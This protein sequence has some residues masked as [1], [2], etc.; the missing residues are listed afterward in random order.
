MREPVN[1]LQQLVLRRL[2]EL[3]DRTG[4]MSTRAAAERSGGLVSYETLRGIARG[5]HSGKITDRT[6]E[7]I[8]RALDVPLAQ[9]YLTARVPRPQSRWRWPERFDRLDAA[10]RRLVEDVAAAMLEAYE[11]GVRDAR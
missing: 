11:K 4:P 1:E 9:V 3:G 6:A 10:Q 2:D 7:G 5:T 8:S